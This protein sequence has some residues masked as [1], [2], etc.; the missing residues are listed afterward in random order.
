MS[1]EILKKIQERDDS[2]INDCYREFKG[3]FVAW[4]RKKFLVSTETAEEIFQSSLVTLYENV[5]NGKLTTF[6]SSVKTYL[7]AIG[8]NKGFDFTRRSNKHKDLSVAEFT[9]AGGILN[10]DMAD[11]PFEKKL[12]ILSEALQQIGDPCRTLF[13]LFYFENR[14][15]AE[16]ASMLGYSTDNSAKNMKYKCMDKIRV[17]VNDLDREKDLRKINE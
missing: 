1:R 8:K 12:S 2:W 13:R 14:S 17:I 6:T 7:F 15:W 9:L 11:D 3:P 4:V 10:D 5:V 16:I